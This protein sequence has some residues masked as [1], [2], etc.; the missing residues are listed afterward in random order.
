MPFRSVST[1]AEGDDLDRIEEALENMGQAA[2]GVFPEDTEVKFIQAATANER[3]YDLFLERTNSELSKLVLGQTMTTDSGSSRSQGEVH[4]RVADA[5]TA[6]DSEF[7]LTLINDTLLPFLIRHGYPLAG[8]EFIWDETIS[9]SKPEQFKI[10][11][12]LMQHS[13]HKLSR[14]YLEETFGVEFEAEAVVGADGAAVVETRPILGYHI[15]AGVVD[16]NEA[17]AQLNLPEQDESEAIAQRRLKAQLSVLQAATQAGVPLQAALLL[18]NLTLPGGLPAE[19]PELPGKSEGSPAVSVSPTAQLT[20]LYSGAGCCG[21]HGV[22]QVTAAADDALLSL[23]DRLI[24][25][26]YAGQSDPEALVDLPLFNYLNDKLQ[27]AIEIAWDAPDAKLKSFLSKNVQRFSGFKSYQV[28]QEMTRKLYDA[29]GKIRTYR[30]FRADALAVNDL[31]NVNYL[32]TEYEH[33]VAGAQMA[34]KWSELEPEALLQYRTVGDD[35]VR[36]EHRKLNNI[37]L[38]RDHPFWETHYPPNDWNCRCD[39]VEVDENTPVTDAS[40]LNELPAVPRLF[41]HNVGAKGQLFSEEHPYFQVPAP[42]TTAIE[43]QLNLTL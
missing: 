28:A 17:R 43:K 15:E 3:L 7:L 13:G 1:D 16:R 23:I 31:Y 8:C 40:D 20:A 27:E 39:A 21:A 4:E 6:D 24:S 25:V 18:A 33:A 11:Q 26:I 42:V 41:Q 32:K 5:Y 29:E 34:A 14:A 38:P 22:S 37:T 12:G 9:L 30:E 35:L 36:P 2:Y 19:Q 10:V